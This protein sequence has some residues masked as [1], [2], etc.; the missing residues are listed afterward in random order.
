M[1]RDGVQLGFKGRTITPG[2]VNIVLP[3]SRYDAILTILGDPD[4]VTGNIKSGINIFGVNGKASVVDTAGA[5]ATAA[6]IRNVGGANSTTA[7]VNGVLVI[8]TMPDNP[9]PAATISTQGGQVTVPA[10]YNPGGTITASL[11]AE[12][13]IS[14]LSPGSAGGTGYYTAGTVAN[15]GHGAQAFTS[16]G[17]FTVPAGVNEIYATIVG[18]GGGGAATG[19]GGGGGGGS[20]LTSIAVSPG[21][22]YAIAVG[23][24]GAYG[25]GSSAGGT[26]G[27]SSIVGNGVAIY[28]TG[29]GGGASGVTYPYMG[30]GG[31]PGT[32]SNTGGTTLA[33]ISAPGGP[34]YY[35][36]VQMGGSGGGSMLGAG[37]VNGQGFS[38]ASGYGGGGG[39][40]Y[41][42]GSGAAGTAGEV[43]IVW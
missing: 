32:V 26:G 10:G 23:A 2:T 6:N 39:G 30:A 38:A 16:G 34:G 37:G 41:G 4:L 24:G 42:A 33:S 15:Q 19:G 35:S 9:S 22:Q 31:T 11:P 7:F 14:S 1:I 5:T 20:I 21:Q 25:S 43:I 29:G 28:A 27:A 3:P 12:G 8:G 13:S 36:S 40:Y 18:G 17:T